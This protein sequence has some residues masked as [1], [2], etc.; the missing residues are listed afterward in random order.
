[1]SMTL[2][3]AILYLSA[4]PDA[5]KGDLNKADGMVKKFASG[6]Q[7]AVGA[8]FKVGILAV[9]AAGAAAANVLVA[10]VKKA[11][12]AGE[13]M[14]KF[15]ATFGDASG[16]LIEDLDELA[17]ATGRSKYEL[18]E[19]AANFGAVAKALGFTEYAANDL[20]AAAL[21]MAVDLGAFHN[22]PTE[23]VAG[24]IQK[25][26][27]G[28]TESM[29]AL[30]VVINQTRIE[31]ELRAMGYKGKLKDVTDTMKAQA[32]FNVI[33]RQTTDAV[34]IAAAESG[35]FTGQMVALKA[36]FNDFLIDVGTKVLPVLTPLLVKFGAFAREVLPLVVDW[37]ANK[38][39]PAF[40]A[41]AGFINGSVVPALSTMGEWF[42][43]NIL[44]AL[45]QLGEF[46]KTTVVPALQVLG[47]WITTILVPALIVFWTWMSENLLP[48]LMA[49]A[50]VVGA[51]L[52]K[53]FEALS[54]LW[55][56]Y[57]QPALE[58]AVEWFNN[59]LEPIGGVSG[60]LEKVVGWLKDLADGIRDLKLPDWLIGHSPSP[61]E[62]TLMGLSKALEKELTP[63][64]G[65]FSAQL[66]ATGAGGAGL[67]SSQTTYDQ[68]RTT[69]VDQ[70]TVNNG[71][72]AQGVMQFL[73]GA[74][75]I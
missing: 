5:L 58:K 15:E 64:L 74:S 52:V 37:V 6:A 19:S 39:V 43:T 36:A 59:L 26:L 8:I 28:E 71:R 44:P 33:Q 18:R 17:A 45:Q 10:S 25:A 55:T 42:K 20:S 22:L 66:N 32:I 31:E 75:R 1:M 34:G 24:R 56:T 46:I 47:T 50:D 73:R 16:E 40:I 61:F 67:G 57:I 12:D 14:A 72:D 9:A 48:V 23:D 53:S 41:F 30:G 70:M 60:V 21:T 38:L 54:A 35:S 11:A 29:K 63:Q 65:K 69:R 13:A 3:D 7:K 49:V 2:G 27:T 4:N 51:V 68:R 62:N